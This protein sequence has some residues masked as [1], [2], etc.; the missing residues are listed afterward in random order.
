MLYVGSRET[1]DVTERVN[2]LEEGLK[3]IAEYEALD[4]KE[5]VYEEDFYTVMNK[6]R[7]SYEDISYRICN[8]AGYVVDFTNDLADAIDRCIEL[9]DKGEDIYFIL[10][11]NN[12]DV[13]Y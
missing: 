8:Y 3:L 2:T 4:K 1:G 7:E 11:K 12:N 6:D 13:E 10:D 5:G 9:N